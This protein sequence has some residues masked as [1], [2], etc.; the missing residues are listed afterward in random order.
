MA[1]IVDKSYDFIRGEWKI[2]SIEAR[3]NQMGL[4]DKRL[5]YGTGCST[6]PATTDDNRI[7]RLRLGGAG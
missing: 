4:F 2:R 1:G 3:L 5:H 7:W 6:Q